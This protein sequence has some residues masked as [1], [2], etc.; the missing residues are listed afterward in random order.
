MHAHSYPSH[1]AVFE[2]GGLCLMVSPYL[3]AEMVVINGGGV[4]VG[5][6]ALMPS[7]QEYHSGVKWDLPG[8][9]LVF[10]FHSP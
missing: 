7:P 10:I 5:L 6:G 2:I 3:S 9:F 1:G 8:P 4:P